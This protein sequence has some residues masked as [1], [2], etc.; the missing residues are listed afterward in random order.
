MKTKI[1]VIAT[2]GMLLTGC[3]SDDDN[4]CAP[5][6]T[7]ELQPA[8]EKLIGDWFLTAAGAEDEIDLT[9]DDTVNPSTDIFDQL[10]DCDKD[11]FYTF[12]SNREMEIK[13]GTIATDCDNKN[14]AISSW[15]LEGNVLSYINTCHR[16]DDE[17]TFSVD[18]S[19]FSV[20]SEVIIQDVEGDNITTTVTYVYTKEVD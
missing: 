20:E 15:K 1:I 18:E 7:G 16:I 10:S 19:T 3:N 5:N 2:M 17:L 13:V 12:H 6:F 11:L 14:E 4:N 9:D 8:E